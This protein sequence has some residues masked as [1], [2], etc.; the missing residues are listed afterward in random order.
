[1]GV[2]I[3]LSRGY[4]KL[5]KRNLSNEI[6]FLKI[7][8]YF[9]N[10]LTLSFKGKNVPRNIL[11]A[12]P[13]PSPPYMAPSQKS[14]ES[15]MYDLVHTRKIDYQELEHNLKVIAGKE[16]STNDI[17]L[18][19]VS[20]SDF[21]LLEKTKQLYSSFFENTEEIKIRIKNKKALAL[22]C[23]LGLVVVQCKIVFVI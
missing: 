22:L 11:P 10:I 16:T 5:L 4:F 17:L 21:L 8:K 13:R 9:L 18:A 19:P 23:M 15:R 1:M 2:S 7:E 12:P 14:K 6:T 3:F 20:I